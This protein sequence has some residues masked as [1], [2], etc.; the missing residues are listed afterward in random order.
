MNVIEEENLQE[1][2]LKVGNYLLKRSQDLMSEFELIG[3][4]RGLG[5]FVG[6]E[7]IKDKMLRTPATQEA[8]FVVDRMKNVHK[9]LVSSD[10]PDENVVKLK[11]PMVFNMENAD[12]FI[13]GMQECL[14]YLKEKEVS[15]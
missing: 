1:N 10:G 14:S 3:D 8:A 7:L 2:C 15:N 11:P 12:E 9:I 6:V 13:A 4:V 5:L